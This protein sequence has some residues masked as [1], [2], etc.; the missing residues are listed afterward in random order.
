MKIPVNLS[1]T[2]YFFIALI[3]CFNSLY[4]Q[5]QTIQHTNPQA[6]EESV[7]VR[8]I[9]FLAYGTFVNET[10]I[11]DVYPVAKTGI[12]RQNAIVFPP[13]PPKRVCDPD[14][15]PMAT[16]ALPITYT[17][18]EPDVADIINGKIHIYG[19]G[20]ATITAD[21]GIETANQSISVS[22]IQKPFILI[23]KATTDICEGS[24]VSFHAETDHAG[25]NPK[26]IWLVN[27]EE[28]VNNSSTYTTST[29]KDNDRISLI[30]VNND[31]CVPIFSDRTNDITVSVT[32]YSS[33]DVEISTATTDRT[34]AG[35]PV[36]FT[37]NTSGN[38]A[39][40]TVIKWFINGQNT[41]ETGDTFTSSKL[42][43]AD[44]V[45]CQAFGS[46]K[47]LFNAIAYSDPVTVSIRN[48]CEITAPNAFTPNGDGVNDYW[49]ISAIAE[50]DMIKV[51]NRNGAIVF[52]S[53]GYA[54][55]WDGTS[56]GK[57]IP[58][59]T[60]YY[61]IISKNGAKKISG[62]VTILR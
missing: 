55:P 8:Q 35:T 57:P 20:A 45:S 62:N 27:G 22:D 6:A 30:V 39:T 51:F 25:A 3:F 34:C 37:A 50:T 9:E 49:Q 56:N 59:G 31:Y 44:M 12:S 43:D 40:V 4:A 41:G 17:S 16:S 32:P 26:Y 24:E 38:S 53:K 2:P 42:K 10:N 58:V 48:D 60:Y 47:C 5:S 13:I 29:L 33:F 15:D 19:P 61:L 14:F 7:P 23:A 54:A 28:V 11:T 18:S 36:T 46:G 21:N 1:K 52:Q